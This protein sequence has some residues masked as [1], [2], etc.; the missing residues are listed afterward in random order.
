MD[1]IL[2]VAVNG[3]RDITLI[4]RF[5]QSRQHRRLMTAV[6]GLGD[7]QIVRILCGIVTDQTPGMILTA[8][9]D[10]ENPAVFRN[11]LLFDQK[12]QF[13]KKLRSGYR[14]NLLF[15]VAGYHNK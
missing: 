15:V 4:L 13:R 11:S 1:I 7:S 14:K 8:V 6:S 2:S 10:E 9:V 5:H 12:I 3:D